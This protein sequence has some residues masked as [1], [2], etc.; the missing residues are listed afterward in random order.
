VV[1]PE[2]PLEETGAGLVAAGD[3]WFVV[4]ARDAGWFHREGRGELLPFTG[5]FEADDEAEWRR[6]LSFPQFGVNLFVL[7]PGEPMAVYHA[8]DAQEAF[9]VLRGQGVIVIEGQERPLTEWDFVHCPPWTEHT[10]VGAGEGPCVVVAV[11]TRASEGIRFPA[12]E[13]ASRHGASSERD[14]T[15]GGEAYARFP[16]GRDTR[17]RD[18]RLPE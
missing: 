12:N 5:N 8:E 17:Y 4:N 10:I 14:T 3:G 16:S 2:S 6:V 18:G 11:G 1:I 13:T 9:L 7:E 15:D